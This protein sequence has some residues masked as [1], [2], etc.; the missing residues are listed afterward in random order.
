MSSPQLLRLRCSSTPRTRAR[1]RSR[2]QCLSGRRRMRGGTSGKWQAD[3]LAPPPRPVCTGPRRW[4]RPCCRA[5]P[6]RPHR[7]ER[8]SWSR[9]SASRPKRSTSSGCWT[10]SARR[11]RARR[12]GPAP[13][14]T[15][16]GPPSTSHVRRVGAQRQHWCAC[17]PMHLAGWPW[18]GRAAPFTSSSSTRRGLVWHCRPREAA[19]GPLSASCAQRASS[20]TKA[21]RTGAWSAAWPPMRPGRRKAASCWP[22]SPGVGKRRRW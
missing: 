6:W 17:L 7:S 19:E 20:C 9:S 14:K 18:R 11:M 3:T 13:R 8:T 16:K 2:S 21:P 22:A 4:S 12:A 5:R 15:L 1:G 10:P